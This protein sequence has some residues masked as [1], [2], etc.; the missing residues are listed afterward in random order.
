MLFLVKEKRKG[1]ESNS[2][3]HAVGDEFTPTQKEIG[4]DIFQNVKDKIIE[5][6]IE[7]LLKEKN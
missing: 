2:G 4:D 5:F 6:V 7:G 1:P 3:Y